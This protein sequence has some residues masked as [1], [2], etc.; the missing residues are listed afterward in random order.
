[1][2]VSLSP[3]GYDGQ[4]KIGLP[5]VGFYPGSDLPTKRRIGGIAHLAAIFL[6]RT[7]I[8]KPFKRRHNQTNFIEKSSA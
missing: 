4:L 6:F 3:Y 2:N 1:M 7:G 5:I 8:E